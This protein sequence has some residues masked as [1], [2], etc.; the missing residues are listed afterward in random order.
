MVIGLVAF[1][2]L[3]FTWWPFHPLP[4]LL[5]DTWCLSRL[6]LSLFAAW[7][8]KCALLRIG[9]GRF[10]TRSKPFFIGII[11]GQVSVLIFWM[12]VGMIYFVVK[13]VAPVALFNYI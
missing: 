5:I 11:A 4:F 7:V 10:F 1:M 13:S 9:G 8:I 12:L 2:R 6:W 3:R